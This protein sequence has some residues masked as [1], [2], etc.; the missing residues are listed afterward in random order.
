MASR[1]VAQAI[2]EKLKT[3]SQPFHT[4]INID[5]VGII[6]VAKLPEGLSVARVGTRVIVARSKEIV[7]A[8][9][10]PAFDSILGMQLQE[11]VNDPET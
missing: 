2:L 4:E 8:Q 3:L 6:R 5:H 7:G 11:T 10:G 1:A 9:A